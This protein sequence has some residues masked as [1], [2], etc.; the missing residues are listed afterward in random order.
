LIKSES[1]H[2]WE[3]LSVISCRGRCCIVV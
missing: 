1:L 3:N 2:F